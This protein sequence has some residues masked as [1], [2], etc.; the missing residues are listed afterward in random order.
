MSMNL[1][2]ILAALLSLV[3]AISPVIAQMPQSQGDMVPNTSLLDASGNI[4]ASQLGYAQPRLTSVCN[5]TRIAN[6]NATAAGN[7]AQT[8][9]VFFCPN[10]LRSL[11]V[12]LSGIYMVTNT[13]ETNLV[14][15]VPINLSLEYVPAPWSAATSYQIGDL[16]SWNPTFAGVSQSPYYVAASAN[17]NSMPQPGNANWTGT[18]ATRLVPITCNGQLACTLPTVTTPAAATVTQGLLTTDAIR[19]NCAGPC[20][21]A[22]RG[23]INQSAAQRFG[24]TGIGQPIWLG[25]YLNVNTTI[26]DITASLS[27]YGTP[28]N[29]EVNTF[30]FAGIIG[31]PATSKPTACIVGDSITAGQTGAFGITGSTTVTAGGTGYT[32]GDILT[33][34]GAGGTSGAT[35]DPPQV[36]VMAVTTGAVTSVRPFASGSLTNVTTNPSQSFPT[37]LQTMTGG[38]GTGAQL[39]FTYTGSTLDTSDTSGSMGY[40]QRAL[41]AAGYGWTGFSNPGDTLQGW[42]TRDY[43]RLSQIRN[44]GCSTVYAALG[45]NDYPSRTLPQMQADAIQLTNDLIGLGTVKRVVW[46]TLFPRSA[47]T[48]GYIDAAGQ[49]ANAQSAIRNGFNDWL[50][51]LPS[52]ITNII[53]VGRAMETSLNSCL[54]V[55]T[56]AVATSRSIDGTHP[57]NSGH[58]T[59]K[60]FVQPL[61]PQSIL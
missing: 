28:G 7:Q 60:D 17:S 32:A 19:A 53:D 22:I 45:T 3:I 50:R 11:A 34:P 37:V 41:T 18:T 5:N 52:P 47:S 43:T 44:A 29:V 23:W 49:T 33:S 24:S 21:I 56:G 4:P 51:T 46:M 31:I 9:T 38:T 6:S 39:T 12:V 48:N 35:G 42:A 40:L 15:P 26:T 55:F 58:T 20:Y 10:G 25:G 14:D 59:A 27:T 61:L 57:A 13:V 30:N 1:R 36:V 2:N 8:R 54:W 16:V